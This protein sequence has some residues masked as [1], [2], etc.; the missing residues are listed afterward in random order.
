MFN[1]H[2]ADKEI[3]KYL[4]EKKK[5]TQKAFP[6]IL[7]I[8]KQILHIVYTIFASKYT[9]NLLHKANILPLWKLALCNCPQYHSLHVIALQNI[10]GLSLA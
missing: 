6:K 2:S 9:A 5:K 1:T 7:R 10:S 8:I 3:D 4:K